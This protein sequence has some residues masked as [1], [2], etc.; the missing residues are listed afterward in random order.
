MIYSA[1][2]GAVER[3]TILEGIFRIT[4]EDLF[5]APKIVVWREFQG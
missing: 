1:R 3:G 5:A 4:Q 2:V